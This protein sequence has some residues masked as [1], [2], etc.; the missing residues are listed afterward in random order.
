MYSHGTSY[1]R[2]TIKGFTYAARNELKTPKPLRDIPKINTLT[3]TFALELIWTKIDGTFHFI[4][5][6]MKLIYNFIDAQ[7]KPEHIREQK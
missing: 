7:S 2:Y 3:Q 4:Y 5:R 6:H 1:N